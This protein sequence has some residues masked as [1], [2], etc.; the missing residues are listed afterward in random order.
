MNFAEQLAYWY[1]RF[2]GFFPLTNFVLHHGTGHRT[3]DTDLL[4]MRF[5]YVSEDIGGEEKKWIGTSGSGT[6]G[7]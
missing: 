6:S 7:A 1:L 5:P 4:A 2:N 3:S